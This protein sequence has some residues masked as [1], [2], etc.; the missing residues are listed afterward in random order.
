MRSW[1][2]VN[3]KNIEFNLNQIENL[4]QKK[5][6]PVIKANEYGLGSI[7]VAKNGRKKRAK[8]FSFQKGGKT[9]TPCSKV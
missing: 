4:T 8:T 7:E 1:L 2:E 6:I 3:L 5:A 9:Q